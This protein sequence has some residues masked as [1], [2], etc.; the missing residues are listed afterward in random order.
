MLLTANHPFVQLLLER[1]YRDNE[2]TVYVSYK[3]QRKNW[4]IG[5]R[6][7]LRK[8]MSRLFKCRHR[9]ANRIRPPI[10]DLPSERLHEH[11]FPFTHTAVDFFGTFE[12]NFI[13][14]TLKRWCCIF[15]CLTTRAVHIKVTQSLDTRSCRVAVARFVARRGQPNTINIDNGTNFVGAASELK[16]FNKVRQIY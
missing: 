3:L 10:A 9:N 12:V 5:L 2:G 6:H 11:V 1:A 14:H 13:Q 4:I 7:G 8:I 15:T 16:T